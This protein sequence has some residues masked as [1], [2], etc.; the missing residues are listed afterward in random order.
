MR[1]FKSW[2][3]F[4]RKR[5][6]HY[7]WGHCRSM[8]KIFMVVICTTM[9]YIAYRTTNFQH[10]Q[11]EV[12]S[13][14]YTGLKGLPDGIVEAKSDL[15]LKPLWS[16]HPKLKV[17]A[18][19]TTANVSSH[20]N[21]LAMPVGLKQKHNVNTIVQKFLQENF[22][23]ILF[24]YD[25]NMDGWGDLKWSKKAVHIIADNQTKWWFA[26]RFLHPASISL[27]DYVFLWDEDLGVQHFNPRRYLDIVKEEGLEISQPALD[28]KSTEI[29]HRITIRRK[30]LKFHRRVYDPKGSVKCT[31]TSEGPPC[32]GFVEGMAPVF[33][34]AAWHC[35][36]HLIQNDLVHGW[37]MDMKLGYCAQGSRNVGIVDSEYVLHQGIQTLG[38]PSTKKDPTDV[39][40][41]KTHRALDM[42]TEIRRQSTSELEIFKQRWEKAKTSC[43][44]SFE[45]MKSFFSSVIERLD[46]DSRLN[47]Q[48][49]ALADIVLDPGRRLNHQEGDNRLNHQEGERAL[50]DN[51]LDLGRRLNHQEGDSRLNHQK[52]ERALA[53]N[54]LDPGRRLNHQDDSRLN[55]QEGDNRLNH[56]EGE[57]ALADNVLDLGR[58]LNHQKGDSRL[59]HQEGE[60]ALAY[61]V[62]DPGR[63][64]NHQD[65]SRLNHQEGER[66][67]ADNVLDLGRRLNHQEGDSRLNHQ[68]GERALAYNVLDPGRRLNHQDDSRLNHQEGERVLADNVLDP[69]SRLN[70]QEGGSR[71][72]PLQL[73]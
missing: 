33:S 37:G 50:A 18:T 64:L 57:R 4:V 43:K 49:G 24:H 32:T 22:T 47:H 12:F 16:S 66:A 70:H 48:D 67:L 60:R 38:G 15:E 19:A 8:K 56:Q 28:R 73:W 6:I 35:A 61:N 17:S 26:K 9:F 11:T 30:R 41:V 46:P 52:G 58:R 10:S 45:D 54:V 27:Y 1:R 55:H 29:H 63:R 68:E 25:G 20:R 5:K 53:D 44:L 59:N 62:L 7:D 72:Y 36:W 31:L 34:R 13:L 65:D 71:L 2:R 69:D 21:L 3:N 14:A 51:V 40:L 42:R 23:V 39:N